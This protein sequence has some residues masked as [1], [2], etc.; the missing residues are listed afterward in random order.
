[1]S[2]TT[3]SLKTDYIISQPDRNITEIGDDD[4]KLCNFNDV[5]R[6]EFTGAVPRVTSSKSIG[7][8]NTMHLKLVVCHERDTGT[9]WDV[10][11]NHQESLIR[12]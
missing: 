10:S 7:M 2:D 8:K 6:L 11:Y 4:L 9:R 5:L 3:I 12:L 1:M